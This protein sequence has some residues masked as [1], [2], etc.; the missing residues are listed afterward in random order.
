MQILTKVNINRKID[1]H[2]FSIFDP[3]NVHSLNTSV[4]VKPFFSLKLGL[5]K[6][7]LDIRSVNNAILML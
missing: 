2:T 6:D 1:Y 4:K 3:Q 5:G 7:I